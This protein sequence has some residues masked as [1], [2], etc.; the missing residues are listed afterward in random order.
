MPT[1]EYLQIACKRSENSFFYIIAEL[2]LRGGWLRDV[3]KAGVYHLGAQ[4]SCE[5]KIG[6]CESEV[7][8]GCLINVCVNVE[9]RGEVDVEV[10]VEVRG[11]VDVKVK[12]M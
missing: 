4:C 11:K 10:V 7:I 2:S 5:N 3:N 1:E 9:V 12:S 6:W 8:S